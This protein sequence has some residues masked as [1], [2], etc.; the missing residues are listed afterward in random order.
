MLTGFTAALILI[1]LSELGDKTFF[2]SL[3]LATRLP[4]LWVFMGS[5]SALAAMTLISV[6]LGQII[7]GIPEIWVQITVVTLF[8]GFGVKLLYTA[9]CISAPLGCS[10]ADEAETVVAR[11]SQDWNPRW[12]HLGLSTG[13]QAFSLTFLG[14]WGDRT[15]IST[16]ALSTTHTPVAVTLG[17]VLGHGICAGIAVLS[18]RWIAGYLSERLLTAL[19]GSLFLFFGILSWIDGI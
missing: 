6:L 17:A 3:L 10:E 12:S 19:G 8:L 4:R 11:A 9:S 5:I 18:G 13:L 16:I 14:E 7:G 1:T 2:I 15:Q